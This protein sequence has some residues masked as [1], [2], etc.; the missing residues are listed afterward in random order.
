MAS[1]LEDTDEITGIN[2]TPLVDIVLVLLIIF[3]ATCHLIAHRS[4]TVQLPKAAHT[5]SRPTT[6]ARV[7][8]EVSGQLLLNDQRITSAELAH[9]LGQMVSIDPSVKVLL[10]ADKR[11]LWEH[12]IKTLDLIRGAGVTK[13]GTEVES[14]S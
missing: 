1:P 5:D 13:I 6:P 4:M 12:V 10:S 7:A 2:V 9:Q 14:A 8:L 3:M 11:V